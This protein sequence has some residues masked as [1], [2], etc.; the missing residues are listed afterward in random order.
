MGDEE[1]E[2]RSLVV[3]GEAALNAAP[4]AV[5]LTIGVQTAA[6]S[7][8]QALR[9]NAATMERVA[10]SLRRLAQLTGGVIEI[11][12]TGLSVLPMFSQPGHPPAAAAPL[13]M[14]PALLM[15]PATGTFPPGAQA[16]AAGQP[17]LIYHVTNTAK[18]S[19]SDPN[20]V[21]EVLDAAIGAGANFS[22][23]IVLR[24]R[25]ETQARRAVMEAAG[26]DARARAEALAAAMGCRLG[27]LTALVDESSF[28]PFSPG[29]GS[30]L[31][32]GVGG[33]AGAGGP[34]SPGD[35]TLVAR[36]RATYELL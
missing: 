7:A 16:A 25:D 28:F 11:K 21:G 2:I 4:D 32:G 12:T 20:R 27:H 1:R 29:L 33:G 22:L 18:V 17:G 26:R 13:L 8:A 9:D 14:N 19:L 35:L 5:E 10:G 31:L 34:V 24:Q 36:V 15:D 23:G 3:V 30:P 6:P